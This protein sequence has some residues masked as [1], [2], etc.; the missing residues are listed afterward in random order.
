MYKTDH[1][2]WNN[3]RP[4]HSTEDPVNDK[5]DTSYHIDNPDFS[6]IFQYKAKNNEKGG[7]I[8]D[9]SSKFGIHEK[10]FEDNKLNHFQ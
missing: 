8:S 7:G 4:K 5:T 1:S 6:Y 10:K 3:D 2:V 9:I